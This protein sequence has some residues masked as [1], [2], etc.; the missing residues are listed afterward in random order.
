M[1]NDSVLI[2]ES[3]TKNGGFPK[4]FDDDLICIIKELYNPDGTSTTQFDYVS[5]I[6]DEIKVF[7]GKYTF[8]ESLRDGR[9]IYLNSKSCLDE[10]NGNIESMLAEQQKLNARRDAI[11]T[12]IITC[13]DFVKSVI[14]FFV[15]LFSG[16]LSLFG[17]KEIQWGF[18]HHWVKKLMDGVFG[19]KDAVEK[20]SSILENDCKENNKN[21]QAVKEQVKGV[22]SAKKAGQGTPKREEKDAVDG[23]V[24][25]AVREDDI[26]EDGYE[27]IIS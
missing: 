12:S 19:E 8:S 26:Q 4:D 1:P 6:S 15:G 5:G 18:S 27:C 9:S 3:P 20:K 16:I 25:E 14:G 10:F 23:P 11:E 21:Y 22:I 13:L 2:T 24:N 7:I 17:G